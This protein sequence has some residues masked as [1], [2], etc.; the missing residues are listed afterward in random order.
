MASK[1]DK[2]GRH[3]ATASRGTLQL[4]AGPPQNERRASVPVASAASDASAGPIVHQVQLLHL[5][6]HGDKSN[7]TDTRDAAALEEGERGNGGDSSKKL[8]L[9]SPRLDEQLGGYPPDCGTKKFKYLS[10][11]KVLR[12]QGT[13]HPMRSSTSRVDSL[14]FPVPEPYP[15]LSTDFGAHSFHRLPTDSVVLSQYGLGIALYFKYLKVMTWLFLLLVALSAPALAVYIVGGGTSLSEFTTRARQDLPSVLGITSIG[16]LSESSSVCD[17]ALESTE[18]S[19]TCSEGEIGFVKA[20]YSTHNSQGSCSCPERNTVAEGSGFC[21]GRVDEATSSMC[22]IDGAGCFLGA[23]P[24]SLKPCCSF[25]LDEKTHRPLFTDMRIQEH[26]GCG[27]RAAQRIVEG[28]CLGQRSCALNVSEALVYAWEPDEAFG[29]S[30]AS[31]SATPTTDSATNITAEACEA[32]LNDDGD[33][34]QCSIDEP[35][36]LIVYAQCFT[37]RIDLTSAWSLKILGWDSISIRVHLEAVLTAA[38]RFAVDL[39]RV[40]VADIQFGKSASGHLRL[41]RRRGVNVGQLEIALQR[42]EKLKLL[43]GR[44]DKRHYARHEKRHLRATRRL[45]RQLHRH[46]LKLER[47][48]LRQKHRNSAQAVTAFVTFEEEE[49]FHRCLQEY[50]DVGWL[51]RLFQPYAKRLHGKRLRF[52]P[53]PDPTDIVWEN[54]HHSLLDRVMRQRRP[55]LSSF[56]LSLAS[57]FRE[58]VSES[59]YNPQ[60]GHEEPLCRT[61]ATTFATTQALSIASVLLVV[62]VNLLLDRVLNALVDMEKH[63]T[64]SSLVVSR[65]TKVFLAQFCNT[66]LLVVVLN[67]NVEYFSTSSSVDGF[68][69]GPF[70]ILNGE[71]SDFSAAWYNDVGV[72]LMLTMIV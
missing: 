65:V 12:D 35:R 39:D 58:M 17:Q 57:S 72:A 64:Q 69:I 44:L 33:Y 37:T 26:E 34:S 71:Y 45:T 6:R 50:P 54:L 70:Q 53:A 27:S 66:A 60:T 43:R 14:G 18:L 28:L 1:R 29:T 48:Q 19:L 25:S 47:W 10:Y 20:V 67:A 11:A 46:N 49:G 38:P 22:P 8:A 63:H 68:A 62:A 40:R 4:P 3:P 59:F 56:S 13:T 52:R 36:A 5:G 41:L 9:V 7:R 16:H 2:K 42:H 51:H 23:H 61:W 30:C 21:R 32:Q 31:T 55:N 24:V 15:L